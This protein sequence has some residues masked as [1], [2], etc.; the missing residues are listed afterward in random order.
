M[1][2]L[3]CAQQRVGRES[4]NVARTV[5][6]RASQTRQR[7]LDSA[8]EVF[9]EHGYSGASMRDIAG[10]LGITK[11]ALY[12]H[13]CSKEDLLEGLVNPVMD[14]LLGFVET[15]ESGRL[16][17]EEVLRSYLDMTIDG[18][19]G[20]HPLM[21]DPGARAAIGVRF[22]PQ[23][24]HRRIEAALAGDAGP[25]ALLRWQFVLGGIRSMVMTRL[26]GTVHAPDRGPDGEPLPGASAGC[27][28]GR[29]QRVSGGTPLLTGD[30]R[31][32][33]IA[34]ALAGL[35]ALA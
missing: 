15:V 25:D 23:E 26:F 31:E 33:L 3:A 13:F 6:S 16:P 8:A 18:I 28:T 27:V 11:A 4:G 2:T 9:A 32:A 21:I 10:R 20:L 7:I 35:G 30:E 22:R 5:G 17:A 34:A 19:P 14:A 29:H 12:Y 1:G 24:L